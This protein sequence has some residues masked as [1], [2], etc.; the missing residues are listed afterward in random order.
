MKKYIRVLPLFALAFTACAIGYSLTAV[1]AGESNVIPGTVYIGDVDVSG[2]TKEEAERAIDSY[3]DTMQN[4]V[5]TLTTGDK[6]IQV[7][8]Q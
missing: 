8:V 2:M 4:Q 6:Q 1:D 5:F 3:M 7:S